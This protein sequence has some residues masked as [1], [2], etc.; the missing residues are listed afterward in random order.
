[1]ALSMVT[2]A[3]WVCIFA[4]MVAAAPECKAA[5]ASCLTNLSQPAHLDGLENVLR[6]DQRCAT[7]LRMIRR[8]AGM[9]LDPRKKGR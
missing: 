8:R 1:M 4:D 9:A 5:R 3:S 6:Q 7:Q 2:S